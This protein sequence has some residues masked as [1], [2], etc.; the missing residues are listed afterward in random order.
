MAQVQEK[1]A[2]REAV[3][4]FDDVETLEAAIFDLQT[5]GFNRT[6]LS[7]LAGEKTVEEKLGHRY[8]RSEELEDD[9]NVPTAAFIPSESLGDAEGALLGGFLYA[10]G[11]PAAAAV[12]ATGGAVLAIIAAAVIGGGAG[13]GIG[14]I[15]SGYLEKHHAE[16]IQNQI[17]RGGLLLWVHTPDKAHE[18]RAVEILSKHSAHDVHVHDLP[19]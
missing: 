1:L 13:L 15:L 18:T 2:A 17:D 16:Y 14:A 11:V 3:G 4:V 19:A 6:E 9:P 5:H 7:L 10:V 8:Q 12:V